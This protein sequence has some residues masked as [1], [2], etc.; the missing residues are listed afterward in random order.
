MFFGVLLA[1]VIGLDG[2][3]EAVVAPITATQILWINLL[4]DSAPALAL[5]VD[6]QTED[7]MDRP[8]RSLAD[9]VIDRRMWSHVVLVGTVMAAVTLLTLDLSLPGGLVEGDRDLTTARTAAFTVL[10]LAQLFHA[11]VARSGTRSAFH[12][13]LAN[14]WLWGA[15]ALSFALQVAVV[16]VPFLQAAFGTAAL[17]LGQW[18][19]CVAGASIVLWVTEVEKAVR[20]WSGRRRD[21]TS[22]PDPV[23]A[24]TRVTKSA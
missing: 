3:D 12:G 13:L 9:R 5:G 1:T 17:D 15:V 20:R 18:V 19:L 11:F 21:G 4:T 24:R 6:P 8:P 22:A 7:V 10:V 14:R 2:L 16:H 23:P